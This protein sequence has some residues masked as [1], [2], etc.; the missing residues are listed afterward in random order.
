MGSHWRAFR[1]AYDRGSVFLV[2]RTANCAGQF[3]GTGATGGNNGAIYFMQSTGFAKF[4]ARI[5]R[6][7]WKEHGRLPLGLVCG[8]IV[9][10]LVMMR[11]TPDVAFAKGVLVGVGLVVP[12][13][14]AQVCF[15]IQRQF[16]LLRVNAPATPFQLVL[17]KFASAFS[18][19]LWATCLSAIVHVCYYSSLYLNSR[20][21]TIK[22]IMLWR[23][24]S[25]R[26]EARFPRQQFSPP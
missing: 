1:R 10:I 20:K 19:V 15:F 22:V 2:N 14:F 9:A 23:R 3:C 18:M 5:I 7:D 13:G 21:R 6:K 25:F 24:L 4:A 26:Q 8:M 16:G 11:L 12:Y 17:A